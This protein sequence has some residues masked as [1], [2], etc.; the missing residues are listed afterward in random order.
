MFPTTSISPS[1]SASFADLQHPSEQTTQPSF[2]SGTRTALSR[3]ILCI[4][5]FLVYLLLNRPDVIL[6]SRLGQTTWYPAVG[7]AFAVMLAISPRYCLLFAIAGSV[8]GMIFYHQPFVSWGTLVGVPLEISAYAAAT[9]L[10]RGPFRID[11]SLG[12]RRDILR[13]VLVAAAAAIFAALAGVLCLCADHT[14][15]WSQFWSSA[16]DWY[17]GDT[18]GLLSVAPFL[19]IHVLP[20]VGKWTA[21]SVSATLREGRL[22]AIGKWKITPLQFLELTAQAVSFGLL[23]R[24]M[25]G[26][27][28]SEHLFYPAF[29][30][31]IWM[32][33]RRGIRGA[34]TGLLAL[35]F[36]IVI[37]LRLVPVSADTFTKLGFLMLAVSATGLVLGAAVTERERIASDLKERTVFLNSFIKNSPYGIVA[38][39]RD[40]IIHL[41]NDAFASLFLYDSSEIVGKS[42]P[43]L[44]VPSEQRNESRRWAEQVNSGQ[45]LHLKVQRKRK[46]GHLVDVEIHVLP[47]VVAGRIQG[48]YVIYKDI[49]EQVRASVVAKEH[50][51]AMGHWVGELELRTM[52]I[53]LL[54]EMSG[55]LQCAA[56]TE[57]AYLVLGQSVNKLF[58]D[59]RA[60]AVFIYK[61]TG[62]VLQLSASWGEGFLGEPV[63]ARE[64]CWSLRQGHPHWSEAPGSGIVCTHVD[65]SVA[66]A[67]LCVPMVA[68]GETLGILHLC[69][70]P[71]ANGNPEVDQK[72]RDSQQRLA[73]A[74]AS[75]IAVSLANLRLRETLREQ[76]I[77]DPLTG[78][79]NRRFMQESL[80][81]ELQRAKRK[82]RLLSLIFLDLD[83]FKHFNDVFGHEAGDFVLQSMSDI[84]R[85]HFRAEDIVCRYGGEEFAVILAETSTEDAFKRAEALRLA[86]RDLK[87][88]HRGKLLDP[89]T[90]SIG[91]AGF[92]ANG[93]S[94]QELLDCADK[95]LYQSK[96]DGRDR[97]T[98]AS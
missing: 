53:T 13:Y 51:D 96:A 23:F 64:N 90:L 44:I 61:P 68:H 56:N 58:A 46:D 10:L 76:S 9:H 80:D 37:T 98:L 66:G 12:Q 55:L 97:V 15:Q 22:W 6:L 41:H 30:P 47:M 70:D 89:V 81:T 59:A 29:L 26:S 45:T 88:L 86:T 11:S 7:L 20:W 67:Y 40:G 73:V 62:N 48:G 74:A 5:L 38:H 3:T 28:D 65:K 63:F 32:G 78:L 93:Q 42:L 54:N 21:A 50:A 92:P 71:D 49:S 85:A 8:S 95:S 69:Y 27:S 17:I 94:A 24:I 16:R 60:G 2:Q 72:M 91:I 83:H 25:F 82:Q 36:G 14:I 34:V 52:Q 19:L 43:E 31:I 1:Q 75:Q 79:F 84:F 18:I 35:N 39:D 4:G 57:E 77:R 33:M 87:L